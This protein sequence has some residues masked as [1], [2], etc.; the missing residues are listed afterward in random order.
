MRPFQTS[1]QNGE[2]IYKWNGYTPHYAGCFYGSSVVLGG[3]EKYSHCYN[4][5]SGIG[6]VEWWIKKELDKLTSEEQD[7]LLYLIKRN[8]T[9]DLYKD[10]IVPSL[11]QTLNVKPYQIYRL[12][13]KILYNFLKNI[14]LNSDAADEKPHWMI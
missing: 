11:A 14:H 7:D 9:F 12:S 10:S 13:N 6:D 8:E 3:E 1:L 5:F 4:F 2:F